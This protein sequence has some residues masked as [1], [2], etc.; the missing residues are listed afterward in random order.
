MRLLSFVLNPKMLLFEGVFLLYF[1]NLS[2]DNGLQVLE[3]QEKVERQ[4]CE[5]RSSKLKGMFLVGSLCT[6]LEHCRHN[7]NSR[8]V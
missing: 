5:E 6:H 7:E 3:S 1:I 2:A 8:F 4:L